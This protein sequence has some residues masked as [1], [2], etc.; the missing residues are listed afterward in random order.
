MRALPAV[1]VATALVLGGA[2]LA[3]RGAP[4]MPSFADVRAAHRPSD[5]RLLDRNGI[6]LQEMRTDPHVRRLD[7]VALAEVSPALRNAIVA[8]EDRRF[9]AHRGVDWRALARAALARVAGRPAGGA[10]TITMQLAA[11]LDGASDAT[12]RRDLGA[13]WRQMRGAWALERRWSKDEILEAYLNRVTFRGDLEG[14]GA[15][16]SVLFGKAPHGLGTGEALV[17]AALLRAPNA[18]AAAMAA[19]AR[20]LAHVVGEPDADVAGAATHAAARDVRMA[21][22]A[23]A[24]H[25]ARRLLAADA[26]GDVRST[27]DAA[28]Q[29]VASESLRRQ[30]L[31]VREGRVGDGAVLVVDDESGDVLAYVA[32]S[33]ELSRAR[34]VDAIVARRQPGSALKPF[35]YALAFDQR[36]LTPE[37]LID[38]APLEIGVAGGIYRPGNYDERFHGLVPAR[39]ALASSLNVPAVRTL[40]LVGGEA[41]T[42]RLRALGFAGFRESA[43]FYGPA[44]ALGSAEVSLW[45]LVNAYRTLANGGVWTPIRLAPA[46]GGGDAAPQHDNGSEA[47]HRDNGTDAAHRVYGAAAAARVADILADREARSLTF[48]LE[49][50]LATPFWTAVKT[51]TSS[52]MRDNWCVGF[53]ARFT[54]G[55]WVGNASGASMRQVSGITGAA[56]VWAEVMAWLHRTTPSVAP[57]A[58]PAE[59]PAPAAAA[60]ARIAA[61]VAGT[62]LALDPDLPADRQRVPF[63]ASGADAAMRWRIDGADAGPASQP[64]LWEPR[65]GAHRLEL[66]DEARRSHDA[67]DFSVR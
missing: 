61:P 23:S 50:P 37:S 36:L 21:R 1:A 48:G 10:S 45:E 19:R 49:S 5:A 7:W 38:D 8:A 18:D 59:S 53:S 55:V 63:V 35:L 2:A 47:A 62:R 25:A 20:A 66:V 40:G 54:V 31:T 57:S 56:P 52:D 30:L 17:L 26:A 6:V 27:L 64:L 16:A 34:D 33:G 24:P 13:K 39:V 29:R 51:G 65:R 32:S 3:G 4:P 46:A 22:A 12:S 9:S 44:V 14:V 43:E 67:V 41:F 15:A 28:L 11:L 58:P 42:A 60:P